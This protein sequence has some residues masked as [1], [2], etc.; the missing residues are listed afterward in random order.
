LRNISKT[1]SF[2]PFYLNTSEEFRRGL[3]AGFLDSDGCV[4]T[5]TTGKYPIITF[6]TTSKKVVTQLKKLYASLGIQSSVMEEERKTTADNEVYA[7]DI[8]VE[9]LH[10]VP[11]HKESIKKLNMMTY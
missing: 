11:F 5:N 8:S 10:K 9:N 2:P 6:Q 3:V 7:L 4:T 1:K